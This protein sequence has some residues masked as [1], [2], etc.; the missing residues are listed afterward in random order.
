MKIALALPVA[1][2]LAVGV[3]FLHP[4]PAPA[5]GKEYKVVEVKEGGTIHGFVRLKAK[6]AAGKVS[7]FKDNDKG[8]GASEHGTQRLVFDDAT[9][10]VGN[11]LV[12]L[13]AIDAGKDWPESMRSDDRTF[14]IDQKMCQYVPHVQWVRPGTQAVILNSDRADHNI[15]GFKSNLEKNS[16]ADTKFNF[17]SEPDTKKDAIGD[18]YLEEAAKYVVKCDIHPWM[19]AYVHVVPHPYHVLTTAKDSDACKAGEFTLT[20]VPPGTYTLVIWKESPKEE[21]VVGSDGKIGTY[22]YGDDLVQEVE[23]KVEAGKTTEVA[24]V[25]IDGVAK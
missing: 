24:D 18:A 25:L 8:C 7:V 13:K 23:V 10:G 20:D 21:A 15:H 6:A 19:N 17:S 3:S 12:F 5:A 11:A 1:A 2:A 16:L 9:L 22:N 4:T 14:Q